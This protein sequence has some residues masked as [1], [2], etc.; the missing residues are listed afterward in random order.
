LT[1]LLFLINLSQEYSKELLLVFLILDDF[2]KS[3]SAALHCILTHSSVPVSTPHSFVFV[4][5][6]VH[7]NLFTAWLR[8]LAERGQ[9]GQAVA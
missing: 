2:A 3:P 9:G 5:F 8:S 4:C 6:S 7:L 1:Y